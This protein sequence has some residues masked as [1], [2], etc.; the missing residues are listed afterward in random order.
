[1][2]AKKLDAYVIPSEDQHMS[3]GVVGSQNSLDLLERVWVDS[4]VDK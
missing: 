1:M 4:F 3:K 2:E